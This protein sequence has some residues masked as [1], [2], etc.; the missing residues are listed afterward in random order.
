MQTQNQSNKTIS[1]PISVPPTP[2]L[3]RGLSAATVL[4]PLRLFLGLSFVA[5][6]V[7]KL[8]DKEF[9]D[10]NAIGYIGSQL[11]G[12]AK[13]SPVGGFLTIF[14]VP[15]ATIFGALVLAGELA[16]GIGTL[17]GLFSRTAAFFGFILSMTLWLT[18]TWEVAPFFLGSDLPYA[19]A[20]LTL[21]L[22]GAHPIFSL[23]G[24]I[25]REMTLVKAE[26][27]AKFEGSPADSGLPRSDAAMLF[28]TTENPKEQ[29]TLARKRF[30][31]V[32][33]A[34]ILTGTVSAIAW[35]KTLQ[36]K[37]ETTAPSAGAGQTTSSVA[38][39]TPQATA[40]AT[41]AP[42]TTQPSQPA[43][44]A[45]ATNAPTT[46]ASQPTSASASTTVAP[47]T[48]PAATKAPATVAAANGP[49]LAA[50]SAIPVGE[51][52]A[53]IVPGTKQSAY[54]VHEA[55][56]SVKAFSAICTHQGCEVSYSK[57]NQL[58]VCPCHGAQFDASTGAVVRG[59][60]RRALASFKVLVDNGNIIYIQS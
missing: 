13:Q 15:N 31:M 54:L 35:A 22:A 5:A 14:A 28:S 3:S 16:I 19:M 50:L 39:T 58:F 23:D 52:K 49:V 56:G 21:A 30:V 29:V 9:F 6:A 37:S 25:K 2:V 45:A 41:S 4:L 47:T 42:T 10:P 12:F 27:L 53:F 59:P 8:T 32:A 11:V 60:A 51:A 55:D 38:T 40:S 43:T 34:T 18:A 57:A 20:W 46:P 26:R 7:D 17:V 44:S 36:S 48:A 33:G 24:Q 1:E